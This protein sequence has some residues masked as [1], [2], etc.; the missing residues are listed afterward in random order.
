MTTEKTVPVSA[1]N[2]YYPFTA[3]VVLAVLSLA[4]AAASIVV[5]FQIK[6][7]T[8]GMILGTW[9]L[10]YM[11]YLQFRER[12]GPRKMLSI[13]LAVSFALL[14]FAIGVSGIVVGMITAYGAVLFTMLA[15]SFVGV[16]VLS[17]KKAL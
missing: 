5:G 2:P 12:R 6:N 9:G 16:I 13:S 15:M 7:M 11:Y 14:F 10:A 1:D 4:I 3:R 17:F 8:A